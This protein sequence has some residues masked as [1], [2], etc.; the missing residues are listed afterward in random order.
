M[1]SVGCFWPMD[2]K[3]LLT[4]A[5]ELDYRP[6]FFYECV[7]DCFATFTE[8]ASVDVFLNN[9]N[10]MHKQIKSKK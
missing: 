4:P 7:D 10:S 3:R 5:L 2:T 1:T 6:G 9:L 8:P